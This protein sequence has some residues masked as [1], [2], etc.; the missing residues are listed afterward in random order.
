MTSAQKGGGKKC[1]KIVDRRCKGR[2]KIF[3]NS[4]GCSKKSVFGEEVHFFRKSVKITILYIPRCV[5]F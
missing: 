3:L 2:C 5:D 4:G 1:S